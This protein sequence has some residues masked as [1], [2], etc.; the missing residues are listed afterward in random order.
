[1]ALSRARYRWW[2]PSSGS[3]SNLLDELNTRSR[4]WEVA[5]LADYSLPLGRGL[6]YVAA[7]LG[8]VRGRQLGEYRYATSRGRLITSNTYY[9]S[10]RSY[11]AV[12]LPLEIGAL[13]PPNHRGTRASLALQAGFNPEKPI[14]CV[15]IGFWVGNFGKSN[16]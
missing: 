6:G 2:G 5:A 4:Q 11:Q 9:Y 3:G 12:G 14:Y 8:Y 7:G 16:R 15:L 1:M 13:T 10:Y